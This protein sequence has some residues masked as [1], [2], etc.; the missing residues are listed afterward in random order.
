MVPGEIV[1]NHY[2][3]VFWLPKVFFEKSVLGVAWPFKKAIEKN[4]GIIIKTHNN[5]SEATDA[6]SAKSL[7]RSAN[8][9]GTYVWN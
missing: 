3:D 9:K 7:S 1:N 2:V 8:K 4:E 6:K 5:M